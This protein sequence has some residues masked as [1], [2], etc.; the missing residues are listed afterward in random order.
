[1][2]RQLIGPFGYAFL[3]AL[4]AMCLRR[5]VRPTSR[6]SRDPALAPLL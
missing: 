2:L 4:G 5:R 1:V 6:T 3:L